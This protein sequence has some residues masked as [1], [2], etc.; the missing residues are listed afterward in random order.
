MVHGLASQLRG[1]L[2]IQSRLQVGTHVELWLPV[3]DVA[4]AAPH[5][6]H[7]APPEMPSAGKVLLVDDEDLVRLSTADMLEN[8][9]YE[10][11]EAATAE[12]AMRLVRAACVPNSW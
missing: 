8:L 10:V 1:A 3:S 2:T 5:L 12:E 4:P 7:A 11:T 6:G 9:G